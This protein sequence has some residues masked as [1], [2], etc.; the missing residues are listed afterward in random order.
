MAHPVAYDI[1]HHIMVL[2]IAVVVVAGAFL[3]HPRSVKDD[4]SHD[5]K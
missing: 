1:M 2:T 5:W 3:F 4:A